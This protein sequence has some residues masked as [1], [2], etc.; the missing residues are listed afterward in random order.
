[1]SAGDR[2]G[3]LP[4]IAGD[5]RV[6][7]GAL[8][9]LI[10][11]L[12][13]RAVRLPL[14][15]ADIGWI[16]AAGRDAWSSWSAPHRNAFSFTAPDHP[17]VMHELG[18]GLLLAPVLE[19][20]GATAVPLVAVAFGLASV[21]T[22]SAL[23]L[24]ES[25]HPAS[26]LLA[27]GWL[28]AGAGE[29]LF[30]PRPSHAS[31]VFPLLMVAIALRPGWSLARSAGAVLLTIVWT[32]SHG[33]FP[34]GVAIL[35]ASAFDESART[36]ARPRL[37][38]AALALA[39]TVVN[40]YGLHLHGLVERYALGGDETARIIHAHIVE[41]FPL[42]R[43]RAPF[44]NPL[45][46][47]ALALVAGLAARALLRR[48][49]VARAL[50]ALALCALAV[51]QVRHVTLAVVLGAVLL[52]AELDDACG[53]AGWPS[54]TIGAAPGAAALVLP[55]LAIALALWLAGRARPERGIA[56]DLG[57]PGF[58]RLAEALPEGARV[59]TPFGT[60]G[61]LIWLRAPHGARVFFD[62]RNDCYPPDVAE[63]AFFLE[64]GGPPERVT[65]TLDRYG[66]DAAIV[67]A[68]HPVFGALAGSPAWRPA[69]REGAWLLFRRAEGGPP[70]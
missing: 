5:A 11:V 43:G 17:W 34:L 3:R 62:S 19:R 63:A 40:P 26:A 44:V 58:A 69:A 51:Y 12:A 66:S 37:A 61:W 6:V 33:S 1:M 21:A 32:N 20:G 47:V 29:A 23:V 41:F 36:T 54:A 25:R 59:Y 28:L 7:L 24:G 38:A 45:N 39:A 48:R 2:G 18:F 4:Q 49:H 67:P 55:G 9:V 31:L 13:G 64:R 68:G 35:A 50:L 42:W 27:L 65:A 70:P 14:D 30:A 16:A 22:A 56:E 46:A 57:G 15:D 52:H 53:E 8:A 60:A 10:A